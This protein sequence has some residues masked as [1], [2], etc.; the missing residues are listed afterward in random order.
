[1]ESKEPSFSDWPGMLLAVRLGAG[2]NY[3]RDFLQE[4]LIGPLPLFITDTIKTRQRIRFLPCLRGL[5][6]KLNE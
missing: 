4:I 5:R 1:M 3:M 2:R 6:Q